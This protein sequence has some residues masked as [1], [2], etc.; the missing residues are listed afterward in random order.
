MIKIASGLAPDGVILLD[1]RRPQGATLQTV[2]PFNCRLTIANLR[3][4]R[5]RLGKK[6]QMPYCL[7]KTVDNGFLFGIGQVN[8]N[9]SQW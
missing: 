4:D 6:V 7:G 2:F 5:E 8:L 9:P 3:A 1:D